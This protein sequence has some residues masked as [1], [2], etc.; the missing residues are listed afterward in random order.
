M[1]HRSLV[2]SMERLFG[3]LIEVHGG[4]FPAWYAPVQVVVLPVGGDGAAAG[5]AAAADAEGLR[6]EVRGDGSLGARVRDARR[7][8]FVA[9]IGT[10]EAAAGSVSLR[11]RGGEPVER[12]VAEALAVLREAVQP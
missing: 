7:V 5:F 2:G 6:V 3:H 8:P 1:V 9:V 12:R 11:A 4:A 10:R